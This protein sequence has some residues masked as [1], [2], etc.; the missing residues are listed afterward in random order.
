VI[1]NT[2]NQSALARRPIRFTCAYA[3]RLSHPNRRA[4]GA[5]ALDQSGFSVIKFSGTCGNYLKCIRI[6]DPLIYQLAQSISSRRLGWENVKPSYGHPAGI[7]P[8]TNLRVLNVYDSPKV[9]LRADFCSVREAPR[10][11][12]Q[13]AE[14]R[15]V[16]GNRR[17]YLGSSGSDFSGFSLTCGITMIVLAWPYPG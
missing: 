12:S 4:D 8:L 16:G 10:V 3:D 17:L 5:A 14:K 11:H 15:K 7:V 9:V 13:L 2:R 6:R 1:R